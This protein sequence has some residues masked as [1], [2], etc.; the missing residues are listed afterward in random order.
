MRDQVDAKQTK[1]E[2]TRDAAKGS[3]VGAIQ[4]MT[5]KLRAI[6]GD[7]RIQGLPNLASGSHTF[8]AARMR[9]AWIDRKLEVPRHDQDWG[10]H[11]PVVTDQGELVYARR[12]A[13]GEVETWP[14]PDQDIQAEDMTR[15]WET[16]D[17]VIEGHMAKIDKR[18]R[19]FAALH[20]L[21]EQMREVMKL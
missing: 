15:M 5:D 17:Q 18:T 19:R 16:L 8:R 21:N 12:D 3:A 4:A 2:A 11:A 13:R 6:M 20:E 14:V 7:H 1:M 10:A 9:G